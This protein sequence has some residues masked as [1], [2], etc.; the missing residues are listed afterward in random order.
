MIN[1]VPGFTE[2]SAA[3]N[4]FE[5]PVLNGGD[6]ENEMRGGLFAKERIERFDLEGWIDFRVVPDPEGSGDPGECGSAVRKD[7]PSVQGL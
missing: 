4:E 3:Q 1:T 5:T 7:L 2:R 6:L